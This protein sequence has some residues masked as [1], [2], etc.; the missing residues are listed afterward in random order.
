VT[1]GNGPRQEG[2]AARVSRAVLWNVV[3]APLRL[4]AEIAATLLKLNQLSPAGFG[5]LTLVRGASNLFGTGVDLGVARALPKY[6]PELE[7]RDGPQAALRLLIVV[8]AAQ[9]AVL[10]FVAL[11]VTL[12]HAEIAAYLQGLLQADTAVDAAA[13]AE[14]SVFV[15]D[16]HWLIILAVLVL[17]ALGAA[18]DMLMAVLSSFFHQRAWNSI[19][20]AAGLL[21][22]LLTVAA[23]LLLPAE[24]AIVGLLAAMVLAPALAVLLAGRQVWLLQRRLG[25]IAVGWADLVATLR[26]A[27]AALPAGFVRYAAV[28]YLMTVTDFIA[29]FEFVNFFSRDMQDVSLLAAGALLVRMALSYLYMPMV[30]VQVPLFTRVRQGE[31]GTLNGAYQSLMRLQLLLLV[32]GAAG[33]IALAGPSL[34]V[35]SPLYRDAAAIVY[36]LVPCLFL[37]SLLTTAHNA[38]MVYERLS[39]VIIGR[40]LALVTV[41][42][43]ALLLPPTLAL[44]GTALA[45]GLA[46]VAAGLWSTGSAMRLLGLRWPWQFSLRVAAATAVMVAAIWPLRGLLPEVGAAVG[47]RLW[48]AGQIAAVAVVGLLVFLAALRLSGGL[49]AADKAQ[50]A[51]MRLPAKR[52]LLRVL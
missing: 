10:L 49:D 51:R 8:L 29:S 37:E 20:L 31:G 7:R 2:L 17:M 14:L 46:R 40:L 24:W 50:L 12:A 6:I 22:Q 19:N 35:V 32:P 38:L 52:Y 47:E 48:L 39:T 16:A 11:A 33:L 45:F 26:S 36:V 18:Y 9:L 41:I 13:R 27:R 15:R 30:G 43:L 44:V 25:V 23:L 1:A 3:F 42:P 5:L 4:L 34:L 21:P 28:S